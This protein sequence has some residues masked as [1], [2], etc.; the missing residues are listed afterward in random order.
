RQAAVDAF[1]TDPN[2]KLFVGS[3]TAA[4]VG[5]TLTAAS[6]VVFAELDWVPGNVSQAEDRCHR[7]GQTD[8]VLVQHLVL[9][10]SLDATMAQRIVDK[11]DV[12]DR[13]LDI[14]GKP[15]YAAEPVFA[16]KVKDEP[17]TVDLKREQADKLAAQMTAE[18]RQAAHT[19]VQMLAG[20]CDGAQKLDG[21]GFNKIDT[22]I[23]H[24]FA[25]RDTLTPRQAV[26]AAKLARK[27]RGQLPETINTIIQGVFA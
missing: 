14:N 3:I 16:A 22:Q 15:V 7:I 13:A 27:Y 11:Q 2:V 21:H 6:H 19:A 10:G 18:Q 23:G 26:F 1:Q 4:G 5:I 25:A 12:I 9:E 17:A 20:M 8:S 24:D